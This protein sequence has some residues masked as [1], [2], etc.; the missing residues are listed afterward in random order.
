MR[1]T[2]AAYAPPP[3]VL[4]AARPVGAAGVAASARSTDPSRVASVVRQLET[5]AGTLHRAGRVTDAAVQVLDRV[6]ALHDQGVDPRRGGAV[7][8]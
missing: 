8:S 5:E 7:R 6:R 4:A 2:A 1:I 3:P